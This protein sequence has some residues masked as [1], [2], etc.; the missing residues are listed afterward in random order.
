MESEGQKKSIC[1]E[2]ID[3]TP[4]K[5][6]N[7]NS[8]APAEAQRPEKKWIH[9]GRKEQWMKSEGQKK[10]ICSESIDDTPLKKNNQNSHAPAEAQRP[11]KRRIHKEQWIKI[12]RS[13]E[14]YL[15]REY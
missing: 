11:K 12:G 3:D 10:S 8:H 13:E 4:L 15:F 2:S 7:Q 14:E 9:K 1:S 6:N 5:E